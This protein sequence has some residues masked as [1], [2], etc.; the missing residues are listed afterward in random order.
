MLDKQGG[1][2]SDFF[3]TLKRS[4]VEVDNNKIKE[5]EKILEEM[6]A[7]DFLSRIP[8]TRNQTVIIAHAN[9]DRKV[10]TDFIRKGLKELGD[11]DQKGV[12]VSCLIPKGLTNIEHKSLQP[13]SIGDV[14]KFGKKYYHVVENDQLSKSIQ[15]EDESG[16]TKYFYPEKYVDKY[17]VELY[18]H[19]K[20][21]LAVGDTIRLTKT[22]KKREL[23]ANFK[24]KVKEINDGA[25]V[26]E[27][28][29]SDINNSQHKSQII[30]N[31]KELRDAHWDYAQTVTGYGFQGGSKT[32]EID[33]EVSYRKNLANQRSF[34]IG[35]TRAVEHLTMYTDNK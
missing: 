17:H 6:V 22:D 4:I 7:E 30:L 34:Y 35:S 1:V 13:Y 31:P 32:Y 2:P 14:V 5:G 12:E 20:A 9:R 29:D 18:E 19:I 8:E 28:I 15:L 25:V 16:K 3:N 33:F 11:I 10:I 21:E 27:S 26:L 24:Y 23:Y